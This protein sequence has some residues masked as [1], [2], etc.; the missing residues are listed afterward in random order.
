MDRRGFLGVVAVAVPA[1]KLLPLL[2]TRIPEA[3]VG[4]DQ[5]FVHGII[6]TGPG[7]SGG[8]QFCSGQAIA[9][10]DALLVEMRDGELCVD[11][12]Q[13]EKL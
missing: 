11:L 5:I 8:F 10:G 13:R 7:G 6:M 3:Q 12:V 4:V 1:A 2:R 9:P